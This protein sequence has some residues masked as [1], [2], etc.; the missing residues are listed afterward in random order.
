MD[1]INGCIDIYMIY[2]LLTED[3][4]LIFSTIF[5]R[6][7][8][9]TSSHSNALSFLTTNRIVRELEGDGYEKLY[10]RMIDL[11]CDVNNQNS[12]GESSLHMALMFGVYK[13]RYRYV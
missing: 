9:L 8:N 7:Q 4:F 3:H 6:S 10:R 1:V 13:N 12:H 11:G 2:W 5:V